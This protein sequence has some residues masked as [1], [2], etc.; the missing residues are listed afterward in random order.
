MHANLQ[1]SEEKSYKRHILE[2]DSVN[3]DTSPLI[4][5][6]FGARMTWPPCNSASLF[7]QQQ[8]V[9]N[10]GRG[11]EEEIWCNMQKSSQQLWYNS[12]GGGGGGATLSQK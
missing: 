4:V 7:P 11:E 10:V 12:G 5:R 1:V 2:L 8:E 3:D 6:S 9:I